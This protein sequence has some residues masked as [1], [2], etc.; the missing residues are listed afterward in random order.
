MKSV[1]EHKGS[2]G[3]CWGFRRYLLIISKMLVRYR[4][5][6]CT[7][8]CRVLKNTDERAFHGGSVLLASAQGG[9]KQHCARRISGYLNPVFRSIAPQHPLSARLRRVQ[10]ATCV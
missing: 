6:D 7:A 5:R 1:V 9:T 3:R 4:A 10:W 2:A 8:K